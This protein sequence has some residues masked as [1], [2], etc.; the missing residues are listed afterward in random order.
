MKGR[1]VFRW[2]ND[3]EDWGWKPDDS[4]AVAIDDASVQNGSIRWW[5]F[6]DIGDAVH[7]LTLKGYEVTFQARE[8]S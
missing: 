2:T 8:Q 1:V 3:G 4:S 6:D 7:H 5:E